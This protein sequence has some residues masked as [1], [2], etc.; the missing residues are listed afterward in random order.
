MGQMTSILLEAP[1]L[2]KNADYSLSVSFKLQ[3][4]TLPIAIPR[5]NGAA[6]KLVAFLS[7]EDGTFGKFEGEHL[8]FETQEDPQPA[9]IITGTVSLIPPAVISNPSVNYELKHNLPFTYVTVGLIIE[10]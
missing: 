8:V 4:T 3:Y 1:T 10:E 5:P 7:C 9:D 6:Y 2:T